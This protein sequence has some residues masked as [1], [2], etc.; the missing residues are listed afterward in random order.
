MLLLTVYPSVN[1][2]FLFLFMSHGLGRPLKNVGDPVEPEDVTKDTT[3]DNANDDQLKPLPEPKQQVK[4]KW[5]C[6]AMHKV[7]NES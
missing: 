4:A 5:S 3:F 7:F 1:L 6:F 2:N